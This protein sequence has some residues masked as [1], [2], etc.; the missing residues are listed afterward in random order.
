[1]HVMKSPTGAAMQT[2]TGTKGTTTS[3]TSRTLT[4]LLFFMPVFFQL[5]LY[6]RTRTALVSVF[7]DL[8]SPKLEKPFKLSGLKFWGD[9]F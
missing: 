1:M 3:G 7:L 9:D 4:F 5:S 8:L 2:A 6:L